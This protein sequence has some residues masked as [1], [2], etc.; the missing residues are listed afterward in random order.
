MT[1]VSGACLLI[2]NESGQVPLHTEVCFK[3]QPAKLFIM[4]RHARQTKTD[5]SNQTQS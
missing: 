4:I 5:A 2:Y 1:G 3:R